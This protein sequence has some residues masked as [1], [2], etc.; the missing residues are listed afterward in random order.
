MRGGCL[1]AADLPLSGG[2][3]A[4]PT[5]QISGGADSANSLSR[6]EMKTAQH[7]HFFFLRGERQALF[8]RKA[9]EM[10]QR[11][12]MAVCVEVPTGAPSQALGI[13]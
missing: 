3:A 11:E 6:R 13:D 12:E 4:G 1:G 2:H 9:Y 5:F 10:E 8:N 7:Q